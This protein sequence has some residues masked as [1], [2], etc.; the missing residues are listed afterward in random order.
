M[1]T[2][3]CMSTHPWQMDQ[4]ELTAEVVLCSCGFC[5]TR[6]DLP[7]RDVAALMS[8]TK[9]IQCL[10]L[11]VLFVCWRLAPGLHKLE[12]EFLR[13]AI[14]SELAVQCSS[15]GLLGQSRSLIKWKIVIHITSFKWS[16]VFVHVSHEEIEWGEKSKDKII[17]SRWIMYYSCVLKI[18]L[19]FIWKNG[20][21]SFF[22]CSKP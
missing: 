3:S 10:F 7:R 11:C 12:V 18:Q 15:N 6:Y 14:H 17:G 13:G 16:Y 19:L 4:K 22:S 2:I 8:F 9:L 5:L 21:W 20:F 1:L